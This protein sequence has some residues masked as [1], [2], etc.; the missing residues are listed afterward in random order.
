[1]TVGVTIQELI[2]STNARFNEIQLTSS[3]HSQAC[4]MGIQQLAAQ[5]QADISSPEDLIKSAKNRVKEKQE[6]EC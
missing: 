5:V 4:M 1:M 2:A 6:L 3:I